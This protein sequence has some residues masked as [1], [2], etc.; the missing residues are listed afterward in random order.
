MTE[1]ALCL[2]AHGRVAWDDMIPLLDGRDA[3]SHTLNDTSCLVTE[4][5]WEETLWVVSIEGINV[6]IFLCFCDM[7]TK[8]SREEMVSVRKVG[9]DIGMYQLEGM[10][11]V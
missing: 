11:D 6:Y 9:K 7:A 4:D 1:D 5:A 10:T 8:Q 3:F 2:A